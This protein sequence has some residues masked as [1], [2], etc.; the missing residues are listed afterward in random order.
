MAYL[1]LWSM[2]FAA[3]VLRCFI[4]LYAGRY[5]LEEGSG[6]KWF[7]IAAGDEARRNIQCQRRSSTTKPAPI[8]L[9]TSRPA[10]EHV[11]SPSWVVDWVA[12]PA[13]SGE[14]AIGD[15]ILV[16]SEYSRRATVG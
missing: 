3:Q 12:E 11:S 5:R 1:E 10:L 6:D 14:S 4:L 7:H 9:A 13:G 8:S 15:E 2:I 16:Q